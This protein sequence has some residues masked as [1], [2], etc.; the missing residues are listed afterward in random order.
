[1]AETTN[2]SSNDIEEAENLVGSCLCGNVKYRVRNLFTDRIAHCH[3]VDCRKFHGA[4][5]STFAG[6]SNLVWTSGKEYLREYTT[7]NGAQRQFCSHC[8]SSLT[9]KGANVPPG[10]IEFAL[11]TLDNLDTIAKCKVKPDAHIF[12]SSK[13]TWINIDGDELPQYSRMRTSG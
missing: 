4:A 10:H 6:T 3:C 1:M 13:A 8:G 2:E 7:S 9:F 11:A 5:F 12:V